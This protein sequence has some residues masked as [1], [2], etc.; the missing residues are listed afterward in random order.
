MKEIYSDEDFEENGDLGELP[1]DTS[2]V[3]FVLKKKATCAVY[4]NCDGEGTDTYRLMF[5]VMK[6]YKISKEALTKVIKIFDDKIQSLE[7][8]DEKH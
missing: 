4:F 2:I 7:M 3:F 5:R 6:I 8:I 1:E